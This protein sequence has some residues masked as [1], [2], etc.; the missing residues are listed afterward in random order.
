MDR[1]I[2][3]FRGIR[4]GN[5]PVYLAGRALVTSSFVLG[6]AMGSLQIL[7]I[8]RASP[9]PIIMVSIAI[10]GVI[11]CVA[12]PLIPAYISTPPWISM[13]PMLLISP[14]LLVVS[15]AYIVTWEHSLLLYMGIMISIISISAT[16]SCIYMLRRSRA[17]GFQRTMNY[18][19]TASLAV[20]SAHT[21]TLPLWGLLDWPHIIPAIDTGLWCPQY[22]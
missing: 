9:H 3:S 5:Q 7:G 8:Y 22:P 15:I 20:I 16:A 10:P 1:L 11:V 12:T 14:A 21:L 6:I 4:R 18:L 17:K 13:I 2:Q 19:F